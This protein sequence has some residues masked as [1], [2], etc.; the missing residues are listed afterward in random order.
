M[1]VNLILNTTVSGQT[2]LCGA[3]DE[4]SGGDLVC[5][6][7]KPRSVCVEFVTVKHWSP[8]TNTISEANSTLALPIITIIIIILFNQ[9]HTEP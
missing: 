4:Y 2:P 9:V 5:C 3:G 6:L 7:K 8:L 1:E